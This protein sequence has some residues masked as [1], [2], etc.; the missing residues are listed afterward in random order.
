[1]NDNL[2]EK[3]TEF[4]IAKSQVQCWIIQQAE[5]ALAWG[6]AILGSPNFSIFSKFYIFFKK[7]H[8]FF[9][10]FYIFQKKNTNFSNIF[11]IISEIQILI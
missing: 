10:I 9:K 11:F 2:T 6:P 8:K 1:M 3:L 4:F 7:T 5:Q